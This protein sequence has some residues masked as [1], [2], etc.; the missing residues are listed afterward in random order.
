M[1]ISN[2]HH[3][4][5]YDDLREWLREADRLGELRTV[6]GA[7]WKGDI[8]QAA[9]LVIREDDG[10]A[11]LFDDVEGSPP[12]YRILINVFAGKRRNMT[13]GFPDELSKVELS[14][15][16]YD[17]YVSDRK[18]IPPVEVEDGP[19]FENVLE[20]DDVDLLKFPTPFWHEKDGGRYIGT[21]CYSVT[22]DPD[23]GWLNVGTY[24]AMVHDA[25]SIGVLMVPGKHGRIHYEKHKA[26][27]D[28]TLSKTQWTIEK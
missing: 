11:V 24:R 12:G 20:G 10:P 25:K 2:F 26:A 15:A 8:G 21:G 6:K 5:A 18:L 7:S 19:V 1:T 4:M 23:D 17:A 3:A 14:D 16:C 13:L 27:V 9:D 22:R 28:R